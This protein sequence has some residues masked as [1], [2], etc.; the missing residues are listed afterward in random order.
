MRQL[1]GI[2]QIK[3]SIPVYFLAAAM[4]VSCPVR[5]AADTSDGGEQFLLGVVVI[6]GIAAITAIDFAL[7]PLTLSY[8]VIRSSHYKHEQ[9]S[10]EAKIKKLRK[11]LTLI[12]TRIQSEK[13]SPQVKPKE[14][15][16][17]AQDPPAERKCSSYP[18]ATSGGNSARLIQASKDGNLA[19]VQ[20]LI[21]EGADV[22]G[23]TSDG[24]TPIYAASKN[25]YLKVV[26]YLVNHCAEIGPVGLFDKTP[27]YAASAGGHLDIVKY[28]L[29]QGADPLYK[30]NIAQTAEDVVCRDALFKSFCPKTKISQILSAEEE[31]RI[32]VLSEKAEK[33]AKALAAKKKLEKEHKKLAAG[34]ILWTPKL[35]ESASLDSSYEVISQSSSAWDNLAKLV[36]ATAQINFHQAIGDK[37]QPPGDLVQGEYES[38]IQFERRVSAAKIAYKAAVD[39]YNRRVRNYR[40]SPYDRNLTVQNALNA[41]LGV[42]K[43]SQVKYNPDSQRFYVEVVS[44]SQYAK[45]FNQ[46]F[47][48][49]HPVP[50]EQAPDVD[51]ELKAASP[52]VVFQYKNGQMEVVSA[53]FKVL[54]QIY[55]ARP[56]NGNALQYS[57]ASVN[58]ANATPV[59]SAR[60]NEIHVQYFE[61]PKKEVENVDTPPKSMVKIDP[62]AYALVIGIEKYQSVPDVEFAD[63]DSQTMFKYLTE[64]MGFDSDN[65]KLVQDQ[66]ATKG[67]LEAS[68][69]WLSNRATKKS[70]IFVY[71]AGHGA[72]D[73]SGQAYIVPYDGEP[74]Y[75]KE[76]AIPSTKLY[77]KLAMLPSKDVTVVLDACF[78][79]SGGRSVIAKGAR[80]LVSVM[81]GYSDVG[82][83]TLILAA[84]KSNEISTA[85]PDGGHG[86]L[87]YFLLKGLH[88]SA[89]QK[90]G[91]VTTQSLFKYVEPKV[92][93]QAR[94]DNVNQTP[95]LY[96]ENRDKNEVW[97]KLK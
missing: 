28:L 39:D 95:T 21:A 67:K 26:K 92:Q 57:L 53:D 82:K 42:P 17:V 43:I 37:P 69:Q 90:D 32:K 96:P 47:A 86:L 48:L 88:G 62:H 84:T 29:K 44:Q 83:N 78:S 10:R 46:K 76:T 59:L 68:L 51:G 23:Y 93:R 71:Y 19:V 45:G 33:I 1:F 30:N 25:G 31:K 77:R 3:K 7:L 97:I 72:P 15:T 65:V 35:A 64:S 80:P 34:K 94:L 60:D 79:G 41:I 40:V 54:G 66:D 63:R 5:A 9:L 16:T 38:K 2:R 70:K 22:N 8:D 91:I 75:L 12:D 74:S 11:E 58:L 87:T 20:A 56:A 49:I 61:A 36:S 27:L 52:K 89:M 6:A 24:I 13:V 73:P 55:Q 85:Y 50:N 4:A 14:K 81:T 18:Q